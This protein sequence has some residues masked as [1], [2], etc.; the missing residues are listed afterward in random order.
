MPIKAG[1]NDVALAIVNSD[2]G[3]QLMQEI[4]RSIEAMQAKEDACWRAGN[5]WRRAPACCCR[6]ASPSHSC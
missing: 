2:S 4:R 1:N 5:R 3:F 6:P